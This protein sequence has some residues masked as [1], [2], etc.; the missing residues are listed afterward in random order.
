MIK[1]QKYFFTNFRS[2][3]GRDLAANSPLWATRGKL[4]TGK[5]GYSRERWDFWKSR[6]FEAAA[7]TSDL[8]EETKKISRSAAQAMVFS[9]EEVEKF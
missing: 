9:A 2:R 6:F 4:W 3:T 1:R 5:P 7:R 8:D